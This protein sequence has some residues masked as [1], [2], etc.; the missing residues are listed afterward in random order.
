MER[1]RE[2]ENS[3]VTTA[4]IAAGVTATAVIIAGIAAAT[5]VTRAAP[6]TGTAENAE[7]VR[8]G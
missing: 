7:T 1:P 4:R 3:A 5:V 2:F 6:A 8:I